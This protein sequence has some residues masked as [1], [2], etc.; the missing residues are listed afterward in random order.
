MLTEYIDDFGFS[1]K[2]KKAL[3]DTDQDVDTT[4]EKVGEERLGSS[5]ILNNIGV[6]L[7]FISTILAILIML[8]A[9]ATYVIKRTGY[10]GK[11]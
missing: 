2:I 6:T 1:I 8:I 7:L 3:F 10:K 11:I 4:G 5:N 9:L